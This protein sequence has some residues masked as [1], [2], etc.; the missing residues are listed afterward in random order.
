VLTTLARHTDASGFGLLPTPTAQDSVGSRNR[1]SSRPPDSQHHDGITLTDA[2]WMGLL[3]TP[4]STDGEK[5]GPNQRGSKGDMALPM[6][7]LML[8]TPSAQL[9]GENEDYLSSLTTKDG[10]PANL[11]ER[12]YDPKTGKHVQRTLNRVVKM[13]MLPT[14]KSHAGSNRRTKLTPAQMRGE[15]GMDLSAAVLMLPT[16][17]EVVTNQTGSAGPMRLNP[18]FVQWMMGYPPGWL[19]VECPRSKPSA[20]P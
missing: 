4:R 7:V 14:P 16:P 5:G 8:P 18:L 15:A 2:V 12:A 6:A 1:T 20:T 19:D 17:D 10:R 13:G 9:A 3:P 11:E